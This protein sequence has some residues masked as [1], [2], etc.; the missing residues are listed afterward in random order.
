MV[1]SV[2]SRWCVRL[3]GLELVS[4]YS[5]AVAQPLY[6]L[7]GRF[8]TF[9]SAHAL[10]HTELI[11]FLCIV[12]FAI[13]LALVALLTAIE[14]PLPALGAALRWVLAAVFI[15]LLSCFITPKV[16]TDTRPLINLSLIG[17]F[18][19]VGIALTLRFAQVR[20]GLRLAVIAAAIF[21]VLLLVQ[22]P[23]G[24]LSL[25]S[26]ASS[27]VEADGQNLT[28]PPNVV[29]LVFDE[30]PLT[31]LLG[32]DLEIRR[33]LFPNFAQLADEADWYTQ[34]STVASR[35]RLA[36]PALLTGKLPEPAKNPNIDDH[37][38]NIFTIL[39]SHYEL[40]V[41]ESAST[42][43]AEYHRVDRANWR[44]VA[45]DSLVVYAHLVAPKFLAA[46]L[47]PLTG[48]WSSFLSES[49]NIVHDERLKKFDKWLD[50]LDQ[51]DDPGLHFLHSLYPH[52]PYTSLPTKHRLFRHGTTS[53]HVTHDARDE[54]SAE[55]W[56]DVEA[57]YFFLW[58]LQLVDRMI[59][60]VMTRMQSSGR[61][62]NTLF[63]VTA[64]HGVR[65]APGMSRRQ[66]FADN[67]IDI[68]AVPVFV[69][70]P[71]QSTPQRIER[72]FQSTDL[73][74]II[75]ESVG[76][77]PAAF[78]LQTGE[79][80]Q[81]PLGRRIRS[82]REYIDLPQTLDLRS[83]LDWWPKAEQI[84]PDLVL[85][86]TMLPCE[87]GIELAHPELYT[88]AHPQHFLAAHVLLNDPQARQSAIVVEFNGRRVKALRSAADQWSAFVPPEAFNAGYNALRIVGQSNDGWCLLF[89]NS[90]SS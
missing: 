83:G 43:A 30:L 66:P 18:G 65:L 40:N 26:Q 61:Y 31:A 38:Q 17:V 89:D 12:S 21:P 4:L 60:E 45:L 87:S 24:Y 34:A 39:A 7:I 49:S 23:S 84:N 35:T 15:L 25:S 54:L 82:Y 33:D 9:L 68:A 22:L 8:P 41:E 85:P 13:P 76:L 81:K 70:R 14:K 3:G 80:E 86:E 69:K 47:P 20:E 55:V 42:L 67:Y 27:V 59:G 6:D 5:L 78:G 56:A 1:R 50:R 88:H 51:F 16:F 79:V 29:M 19:I 11:W 57:R 74:P 2:E 72:A 36:L 75:L 10:L 32:S 62:D 52:I 71:G 28:E 63:V 90:S 48:Q 37:P 73:L 44:L 64:D 46:R 58:Q 53:G 77:D